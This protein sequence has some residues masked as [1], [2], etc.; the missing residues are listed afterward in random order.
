MKFKFIIT[1][2]TF[3]LISC[4]DSTDGEKERE[5][6]STCYQ[7][8]EKGTN[9][10]IEGLSIII[11]SS[12]PSG[13]DRV[14]Q[15]ITDESGNY[16]IEHYD[17]LGSINIFKVMSIVVEGSDGTPYLTSNCGI[18]YKIDVPVPIQSIIKLDPI[19]YI[20]FHIKKESP[21][22]TVDEM[23]VSLSFDDCG[24]NVL[25]IQGKEIDSTFVEISRAG[26][27]KIEW[28]TRLNGIEVQK[29]SK[30]IIG[31]KKDTLFFEILY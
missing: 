30:N 19:S 18:P 10:P 14:D 3:F 7:F 24:S 25:W 16:C 6:Y 2:C 15:G 11:H 12:R 8:L 13:V 31:V 21:I 17:P 28:S 20:K 27:N 5:I 23:F 29:K 1:I 26:S 4:S 9:I 22:E